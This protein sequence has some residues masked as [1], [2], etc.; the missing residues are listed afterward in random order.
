MDYRLF[1]FVCCPKDK[2]FPLILE[3]PVTKKREVAISSSSLK[4]QS[5][6]ARRQASIEKND[7]PCQNCLEEELI[8]GNITCQQC[9][10]SYKL[11]NSIAL[12]IAEE[13]QPKDKSSFL[14]QKKEQEERDKQAQR[15]AGFI[16]KG[17]GASR[18]IALCL[19]LLDAKPDDIIADLGCGVG[20]I[21][22]QLTNKA[23]LVLAVDFSLDSLNL[24]RELVGEAANTMH[25]LAD[26]TALPLKLSCCSKVISSQVME[27][28]PSEN[29]LQSAVKEIK[30]IIIN[31]KGKLVVSLYYYSCLFKLLN[32]RQG[33]HRN[34]IYFRRFT[35]FEIKRLF[36][37]DF[38]LD[39]M[40]TNIAWHLALASWH[41]LGS[42]NK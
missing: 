37:K 15:V 3:K 40:Q 34:G 18:E 27:H 7:A 38:K 31:D 8:S 12:L 26:I 36:A 42:N 28:L 13:K 2:Y 23:G 30:R 17:K 35:E 1:D 32:R 39:F 22:N 33:Y 5:Y 25:I 21:T 4:C 19:K 20:R 29:M 6:C 9:G 16:K 11:S 41:S 10:S 24:N 14:I